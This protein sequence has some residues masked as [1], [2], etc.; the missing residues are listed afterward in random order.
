MAAD[1]AGVVSAAGEMGD[2]VA[3][4]SLLLCFPFTSNLQ[5]TTSVAEY[6][7]TTDVWCG[8]QQQ[9][10]QQEQQQDKEKQQELRQLL[11]RKQKGFI[12]AV[13][14]APERLKQFLGSVPPFYDSMA[15]EL[16]GRVR[17]AAV[18]VAA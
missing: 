2:A 1:F 9:R 12:V 13:K 7:V 10:E 4:L 14:G 15:D 8:A 11:Q 6:T 3:Q 17:P 5:R 16:T 18:A